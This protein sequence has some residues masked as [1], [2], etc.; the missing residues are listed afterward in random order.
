METENKPEEV[1]QK[2]IE[3]KFETT[4]YH[5]FCIYFFGGWLNMEKAIGN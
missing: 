2:E 3:G 4:F 1:I 5:G